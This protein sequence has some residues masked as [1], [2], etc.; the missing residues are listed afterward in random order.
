MR[1]KARSL[2]GTSTP[3]SLFAG[4]GS[5][6]EEKRENNN[7]YANEANEKAIIVKRGYGDA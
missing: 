3:Q 5:G 7:K 6:F 2:W 1:L 4:I